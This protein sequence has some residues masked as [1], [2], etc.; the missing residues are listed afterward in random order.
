MY[1]AHPI[2]QNVTSFEFKLVGDMTLKQFLYLA[3]GAGVAYLTFI[4]FAASAPLIA[5]PIIVVSAGLG[6]AFAFL[7]L[8]DR[9]LDHWVKAYFKAVYS[10]TKRIWKKNGQPY[11]SQPMFLQRLNLYLQKELYTTSQ[12]VQPVVALANLPQPNLHP[13]VPN[14]NQEPEPLPT[15]QELEQTVTLAKQAQSL[16]VKII[17][18]ERQL[19][20]LKMSAS[21]PG[22]NPQAYT[23]QISQVLGHL[24][25]LISQASEVRKKLDSLDQ[26]PTLPAKPVSRVT[27]V[28]SH[29]ST[30][31]QISL[32]STPNV[33]N[34]I[35]TD[36]TGNYLDGVVVVIY[37]KEGLPVRALKTNKLGQ[38]T[39]STPLPNGTYT[40][41]LEKEG[42]VFDRLQLELNGVVLPPLQVAAKQ[43]A[44]S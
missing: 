39:G 42:L 40:I 22:V 17:E 12:P 1:E 19:G 6:L 44:A 18:T 4:L 35:I 37:D 28:T 23:Q 16:Q 41:E 34:C 43:P 13:I 10:P 26:K 38:F 7:P 33:I 15:R 27:V 20:A 3:T 29:K 25:S 36:N 14:L 21:Q 2:P 11:S 8:A 24:Q 32:T 30:I 9:P 31:S 5:W